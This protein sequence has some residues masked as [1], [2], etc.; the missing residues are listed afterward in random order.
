[1]NGIAGIAE[2]SDTR[3]VVT[4]E[5][6]SV[7]YQFTFDMEDQA[8]CIQEDAG[9]GDTTASFGTEQPLY[10]DRRSKRLFEERAP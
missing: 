3:C 4:D 5:V 6:P 8:L 9:E 10:R 7:K 1:M 2:R